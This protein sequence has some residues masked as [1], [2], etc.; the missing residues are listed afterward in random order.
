MRFCIPYTYWFFNTQ[1]F[2]QKDKCHVC[3]TDDNEFFL[4]NTDNRT[5]YECIPI[6]AVNYQFLNGQD[7]Y[8][9]CSRLFLYISPYEI[10][11][12]KCPLRRDDVLAIRDKVEK[13]HILEQEHINKI[14]LALD[15]W[16]N[17]Q[18]D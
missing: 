18:T 3:V 1:V 8:V 11:D 7:R 4:I 5:M 12:N 14:L 13:S 16:L 10:K 9:S 6:L 2:P 17:N 15:N